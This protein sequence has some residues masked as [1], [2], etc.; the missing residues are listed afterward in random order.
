L[1]LQTDN[2]RETQGDSVSDWHRINTTIITGTNPYSYTDTGVIENTQYEY[3]LKAVLIDGVANET[4]GTTMVEA[5][6][7]P[8]LASCDYTPIPHPGR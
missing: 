4:L 8:D 7:P 2:V 3:K 1:P 5:E 6:S